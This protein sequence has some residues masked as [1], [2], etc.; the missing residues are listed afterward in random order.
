MCTQYKY[1]LFNELAVH[2]NI[3]EINVYRSSSC[4]YKLVAQISFPTRISSRSV[5]WRIIK[6]TAA[7]GCAFP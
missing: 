4:E 6:L 2:A 1:T 7:G 5:P 3:L